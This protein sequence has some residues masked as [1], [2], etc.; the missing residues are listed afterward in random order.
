[1]EVV[2]RRQ[3]LIRIGVATATVTVVGAGLGRVLEMDERNQLEAELEAMKDNMPK[4]PLV[5][6]LPNEDDPIKPALGTRPEYTAVRDHYKIFI[7]SEPTVIDGET[8]TLPITGLVD[9]PANL[10]LGDIQTRYEP[11][12]E[13]VT[14]SCIS[15]RIAGPLIGTTYWTGASLQ[16]ILEDVRPQGDARYLFITSGDGFY[17]TVDSGLDQLRQA[18]H[19]RIQLGWQTDSLRSRLPVADLASR[20]LRHE[21]A[22]VD[23]RN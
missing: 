19:A 6:E 22:Q 21:T 15:N 13:F 18:D 11:R 12:N 17:E 1:M 20:P 7:R 4:A 10:T 9:N 16:D 14:L 3:F 2:G 8:W 5:V 23:H